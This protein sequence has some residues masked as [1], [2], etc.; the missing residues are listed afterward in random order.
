LFHSV[1]TWQLVLNNDR[2]LRE[3]CP[4]RLGPCIGEQ[5]A[6]RISEETRTTTTALAELQEQVD[7]QQ[8]ALDRLA[9]QLDA[10]EA[11]P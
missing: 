5:V 6:C 3:C 8:V 1:D 4:S 9:A 2:A 10:P 7:D 11:K